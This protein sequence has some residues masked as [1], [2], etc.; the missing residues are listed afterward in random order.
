MAKLRV[1]IKPYLQDFVEEMGERYGIADPTEI[2]NVLLLERKTGSIG[3]QPAP[4]AIAF[5]PEP[6]PS[7]FTDELAEFS[8]L[9]E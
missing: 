1:S 7:S 4:N 3:V 5:T 8:G 6:L 2:V 9:L